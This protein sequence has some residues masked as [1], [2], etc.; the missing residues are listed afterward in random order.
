MNI[1][2]WIFH[3]IAY[4]ANMFSEQRKS[5]VSREMHQ[6]CFQCLVKEVI[7][8]QCLEHH[9]GPLVP[10]AHPSILDISTA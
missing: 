4:T 1:H 3:R 10:L 2:N 7:E 6:R 5:R 9:R 8:K